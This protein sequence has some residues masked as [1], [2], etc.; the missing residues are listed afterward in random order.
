MASASSACDALVIALNKKRKLSMDVET[1]QKLQV[2]EVAL[3]QENAGQG[4]VSTRVE[5]FARLENST[6][7]R[8]QGFVVLGWVVDRQTLARIFILVMGTLGTI[9]PIIIALR[10]KAA[11]G[12]AGGE[13]GLTEEQREAI[14]AT[15]TAVL[16]GSMCA[17]D[18]ITLG[19]IMDGA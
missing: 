3:N 11:D 14:R 9:G 16:G 17:F 13:C 5:L 8:P 19:Y 18:N 1:H 7:C 12:S 2:L 15:A 6:C 10:P 4:L